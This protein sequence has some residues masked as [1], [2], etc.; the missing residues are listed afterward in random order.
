MQIEK[1]D[2]PS[3][4]N[5]QLDETD[6]SMAPTPSSEKMVV[7]PKVK[8]C[9]ACGQGFSAKVKE[10]QACGQGFSEDNIEI[11]VPLTKTCT[12]GHLGPII[13]I[14]GLGIRK[15]KL[16][17]ACLTVLLLLVLSFFFASVSMAERKTHKKFVSESK[18]VDPTTTN[19]PM[20]DEMFQ[21]SNSDT[22]HK[23]GQGKGGSDWKGAIGGDNIPAVITVNPAAANWFQNKFWSSMTS[24]DKIEDHRFGYR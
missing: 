4:S 5:Y 8:E 18:V 9:E 10:C 6:I 17:N 11:G 2:G 19:E 14:Q 15:V 12:Q 22:N 16:K 21:V 20:T 24:G 13:R 23:Q 7:S 3:P 1:P